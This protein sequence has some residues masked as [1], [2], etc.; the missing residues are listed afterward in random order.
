[1]PTQPKL[2]QPAESG[3]QGARRRELFIEGQVMLALGQPNDLNR[4][5]VRALW[6]NRFR[7]NVLVGADAV[8]ATIAH[9]YFV[10]TDVQGNVLTSIPTI[11]KKY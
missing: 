7:V 1:M 4:V 5:A 2:A 8:S 6:D 3:D 10:V 9:S 11:I